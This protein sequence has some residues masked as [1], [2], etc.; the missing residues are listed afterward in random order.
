MFEA[1]ELEI[2]AGERL[3]HTELN[4]RLR[5]SELTVLL[6]LNGVGKTLLL[7]T[8]CGILP[9]GAGS[10][11]IDGKAIIYNGKDIAYLPQIPFIPAD[12]TALDYVLSGRA[13]YLHFI[14]APKG[15][16]EDIADAC[17]VRT[18][19]RQLSLRKLGTCSG[20]EIARVALSRL[21]AQDAKVMLLDEPCAHMDLPCAHTMMGL[22]RSVINENDKYALVTM[23]DPAMAFNFAD[24]V[25]C[26]DETGIYAE[27]PTR[28]DMDT[29]AGGEALAYINKELQRIYSERFELIYYDGIFAGVI[30]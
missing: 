11:L 14:E 27:L 1:S 6:G 24:R 9:R 12:F 19:V 28:L 3:L 21:L 4:L 15:R 18:G 8:L 10:I 25:L 29:T 26:M 20:G 22:I 5:Q 2:Y 7:K 23:H 30:R 13:P 16:D 17:M